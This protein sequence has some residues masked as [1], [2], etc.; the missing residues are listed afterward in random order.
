ME[1]I[2]ALKDPFPHLIVENMYNE[3]ELELIWEELEFLNK[4]GKLQDPENYGAAKVENEYATNSKAI[5]LDDVYADR[6]ISNILKINR[7]IF[8]YSEIY[9]KLSPYHLKFLYCNMDITKI[10]YYHNKEFYQNLSDRQ[11]ILIKKNNN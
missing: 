3:K 9:S 6:N 8:N 4:P 10:R 1:Y 11:I 2:R 7:K 5:I